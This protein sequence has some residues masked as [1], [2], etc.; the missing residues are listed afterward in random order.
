[1]NSSLVTV[2]AIGSVLGFRH[3]F[4]PD[5]LAAVMTL[6]TR[7]GTLRDALRLGAAWGVGHTASVGT[8]AGLLIALDVHLPPAVASAA[9]MLVALL[10]IALG[11]TVFWRYARQHRHELDRAHAHAHALGIPHG[12]SPPIRDARRSFGFGIAHGLAGSGAVMALMVAAASTRG[13]QAAYLLAFG[14]GTI[15]GML[16]VSAATAALARTATHRGRRWARLLHLG[17]AALS[18]GVGILLAVETAGALPR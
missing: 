14:A 8:V 2:A 17:S 9:E 13:A 1:M 4:E 6:I 16:G 11:T 15:V 12:H 18:V 7:Q 3:A 10:L 5:H